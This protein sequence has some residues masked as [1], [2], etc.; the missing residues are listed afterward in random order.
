MNSS[1]LHRLLRVAK[2]GR[3]Y[4]L[5]ASCLIVAL[6]IVASLTVPLWHIPDPTQQHLSQ[7]LTP[8]FWLRSGTLVHPFG[9]D[10]L[11]RD[12]ASRVVWGSRFS[13]LVGFT[14]VALA[15]TIGIPLGTVAAYF[16]GRADEIIMRLFDMIL[17][18]PTLLVAIAVLDAL[19]SSLFG[20]ILV[21][22]LRSTVYFSRILRS[23]ILTIREEQYVEA[24]RALG[25][26]HMTIMFRHVL[27][28]SWAP[29]I[30]LSAIYVGVMVILE[31]SVS[32]LGLTKVHV[33][34]GFSVAE[35]LNYLATAW[36]AAT[37]PGLAIFLFVLSMNV[38]GD[39]LRDVLDPR[40]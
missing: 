22:G 20:L 9:T 39:S 40:F 27:P 35:N 17:A 10:F 16:G 31:S 23:R 5:V 14:S 28:N 37:F 29:V 38:I 21:L 30:V 32:F 25:L 26:G 6:T 7:A 18:I 8:P 2:F 4:L 15:A 19:G 33:S 24:A 12:V 3:N 1:R 13:L 34:W 11:G 36:W